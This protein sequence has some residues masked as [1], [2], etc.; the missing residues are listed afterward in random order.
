MSLTL[1]TL[2]A[3][4]RCMIWKF[5]LTETVNLCCRSPPYVQAPSTDDVSETFPKIQNPRLR[6]LLISKSSYREINALP[7]DFTFQFCQ[8]MHLNYVVG[9]IVEASRRSS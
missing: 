9:R 8:R 5:A 6:L 2:P 1:M 4:I 7:S 3:E